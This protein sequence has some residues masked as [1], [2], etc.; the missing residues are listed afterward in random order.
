[1]TEE[2]IIRLKKLRL[3]DTIIRSKKD[4]LTSLKAGIQKSPQFSD[5]PK[6]DSESNSTE[7]LNI[8]I[9]DKAK[10]IEAEISML[11]DERS[12]LVYM[13]DKLHDPIE[14]AV[15]RLFYVN[16]M[17]WKDISIELNGHPKTFQNIR[18]SGIQNLISIYS[19]NIHSK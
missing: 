12:E 15:L 4:E 5:E 2:I 6:G 11:Y 1:M 14:T 17:S 9:V 7:D 8:K 13:I 19:Q 10:E 3:F 18:K 16:G